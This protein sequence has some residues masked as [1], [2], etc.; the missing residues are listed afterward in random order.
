MREKSLLKNFTV[1]K[2]ENEAQSNEAWKVTKSVELSKT[3]KG[4]EFNFVSDSS[5]FL[6]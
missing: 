4:S 5:F 6:I 2:N 3:T 1:I